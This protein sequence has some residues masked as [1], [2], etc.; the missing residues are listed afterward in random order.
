MPDVTQQ[1][2]ADR[3]TLVLAVVLAGLAT[4]GPF[5]IDTYMPSFPAIGRSFAATPRDWDFRAR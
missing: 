4:L 1:K 5:A 3:A 2:Q